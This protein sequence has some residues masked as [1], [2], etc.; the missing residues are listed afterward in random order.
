ME[1]RF[2]PSTKTKVDRAKQLGSGSVIQRCL[3]RDGWIRQDYGR[4]S[5]KIMLIVA[6]GNLPPLQSKGRAVAER[7]T[8]ANYYDRWAEGEM[9]LQ[10]ETT[11]RFGGEASVSGFAPQERRDRDAVSD[12]IVAQWHQVER[13][14]LAPSRTRRGR[15]RAGGAGAGATSQKAAS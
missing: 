15:I 14:D 4:I 1:A 6:I 9:P 8:F 2:G 10:T 12:E 7:N 11:D 5:E 13:S 3:Y